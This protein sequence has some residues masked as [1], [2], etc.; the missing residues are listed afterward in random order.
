MDK[1][2]TILVPFNFSEVSQGALEYAVGYVGRDEN[3]KIIVAHIANGSEVAPDAFNSIEENYKRILKHPIEFVSGSGSLTESLM[4]I[5]KR[6]QVDLIIM[7]THGI[8]GEEDSASTNTSKLVAEAD[9]PVLVVPQGLGE[10]Q[11]KNI[12]LVLGREEIDDTKVLGTLLDVARRFNAKVHVLTIENKPDVYGYSETDEKNE[13]AI[14]Y[15]L[16]SF[17]SEHTFIENPDVVEGILG[18]ATQKEIDVI[19]ILPR[20]HTKRSEPSEGQLTQMLT[21]H[22]KVPLLAI[23]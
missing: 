14:Q 19:A 21:L 6:E 10:F 20:N 16:E 1:I 7:G 11:I 23:N 22:S 8:S 13:N 15:Y 4:D 18:Y 17:Y 5:Q 2:A 9:C 3:L 12:S